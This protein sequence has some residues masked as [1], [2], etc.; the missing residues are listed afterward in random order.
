M[1]TKRLVIDGIDSRY[2]ISDTGQIYSEISNRYL[3]PFKNPSG[4]YLVDLSIGGVSYTRQ[5]HRLVALTFIEN[6]NKLETVNHKNGDKSDNNVQNLEWMTQ[7]DNV[8]HAWATGLVKPRYGI[9][10]PSNV[11]TEEQIHNVC[12]MLEVGISNNKEIAEKCG[13]NVTLIRDIKFRGK[14]KHI[15]SLYDISHI[16]AGHKDLRDK[17]FNLISQGKSNKEI[18]K[19]LG[20][21]ESDR[22]HISYVRSIYKLKERIK[23]RE[24]AST[25]NR[26]TS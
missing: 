15:S 10:N 6:P 25:T 22:R 11:Y 8:R 3:K 19:I 5:V 21:P 9:D 7:L 18:I 16:P 12:K 14:W 13:V 26:G 24:A 4:Y 1:I 17:I 23:E 20:L 2:L